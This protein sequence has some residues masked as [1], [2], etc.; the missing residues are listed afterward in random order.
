MGLICGF[1][2]LASILQNYFSSML[3]L[4]VISYVLCCRRMLKSYTNNIKL[5]QLQIE[6]LDTHQQQQQQQQGQQEQGQLQAP[7]PS[8]AATKL[9]L[10]KL[11]QKGIIVFIAAKI[12]FY[13]VSSLLLYEY[14]WINDII[15]NAL[16]IAFTLFLFYNFRM[17]RSFKP[18]FYLIDDN[19]EEW[20]SAKFEQRSFTKNINYNLSF[21]CDTLIVANNIDYFEEEEENEE[22]GDS[23]DE[24]QPAKLITNYSLS[25]PFTI[26]LNKSQ[27]QSKE[28]Q[29]HSEN[30]PL[31]QK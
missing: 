9:A 23:E 19:V 15:L 26:D 29:E 12:I 18:Y 16:T 25:T 5:L 6:I 4:T 13:W 21:Q 10:F 14:P 1:I 31:L 17:S 2:V 3:L 28:R 27:S 30:T 7:S 20:D 11:F 22:D 24:E 8:P